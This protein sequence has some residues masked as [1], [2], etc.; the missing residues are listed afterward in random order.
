[1]IVA[2]LSFGSSAAATDSGRSPDRQRG[3]RMAALR[4][5]AV[6][7]VEELLEPVVGGFVDLVEKTA[8]AL[9]ALP[10]RWRDL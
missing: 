5:Q 7:S 2:A 4:Q 10:A 1:M 6:E 8:S 9:A 3:A